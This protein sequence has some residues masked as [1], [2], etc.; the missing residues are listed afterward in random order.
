M[1]KIRKHKVK[2][3]CLCSPDKSISITNSG[4]N[5]NIMP[6]KIARLDTNQ[7]WAIS[8]KVAHP[9]GLPFADGESKSD[10]SGHDGDTSGPFNGIEETYMFPTS[11]DKFVDLYIDRI[12]VI[13]AYK[14]HWKQILNTIN[15]GSDYISDNDVRLIKSRLEML[16]G[17]YESYIFIPIYDEYPSIN[18]NHLKTPEYVETGKLFPE[19][20]SLERALPDLYQQ[21]L[22]ERPNTTDKTVIENW[23]TSI[24]GPATCPVYSISPD[25]GSSV[26]TG[27]SHYGDDVGSFPW[28]INWKLGRAAYPPRP[29][30]VWYSFGSESATVIPTPNPLP[31]P[32]APYGLP[33]DGITACGWSEPFPDFLSYVY[34][35][36]LNNTRDLYTRVYTQIEENPDIVKYGYLIDLN[37][38]TLLN[39]ST[40]NLAK[41][42][43]ITRKTKQHIVTVDDE[44]DSSWVAGINFGQSNVETTGI[45]PFPG[46]FNFTPPDNYRICDIDRSDYNISNVD[47]LNDLYRIKFEG[48]KDFSKVTLKVD[49]NSFPV[50]TTPNTPC[51]YDRET[52]GVTGGSYDTFSF[53]IEEINFF[54]DIV[55]LSDDGQSIY[56]KDVLPITKIGEN[57]SYDIMRSSPIFDSVSLLHKT[58]SNFTGQDTYNSSLGT[59]SIGFDTHEYKIKSGEFST[60]DYTD[61]YNIKY[62]T[63]FSSEKSEPYPVPMVGPFYRNSYPYISDETAQVRCNFKQPDVKYLSLHL[64]SPNLDIYHGWV[65]ANGTYIYC[66][67]NSQSCSSSVDIGNLNEGRGPDNLIFSDTNIEDIVVYDIPQFKII[68]DGYKEIDL[69]VYRSGNIDLYDFNN[70]SGTLLNGNIT[71]TFFINSS[72]KDS[73]GIE[74]SVF[75]TAADFYD[76]MNAV[77]LDYNPVYFSDYVGLENST[78]K[79][80]DFDYMKKSPLIYD[81][82]GFSNNEIVLN[83][84]TQFIGINQRTFYGVEHTK[85]NDSNFWIENVR[86]F[87]IDDVWFDDVYESVLIYEDVLMGPNP[88]VGKIFKRFLSVDGDDS[89]KKYWESFSNV[90]AIFSIYNTLPTI[91]NNMFNVNLSFSIQISQTDTENV[92]D[93]KIRVQSVYGDDTYSC[94]EDTLCNKSTQ[95]FKFNI[96]FPVRLFNQF[97][98]ISTQ[99]RPMKLIVKPLE[100][101]YEFSSLLVKP[102]IPIQD[103]ENV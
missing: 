4:D 61:S 62:T 32:N 85:C 73:S 95:G 15:G 89:N 3:N 64:D 72:T 69:S 63:S 59:N 91:Q 82:L 77:V 8:S 99:I 53:E 60:Y 76:Q 51:G 78:K 2:G 5:Y 101:D 26:L 102:N 50:L 55:Q 33:L 31:V 39:N 14:L 29:M 58:T 103:I 10:Y 34:E 23:I 66:P 94:E 1:S 54:D 68:K 44:R 87:K 81:Y 70:I 79:F 38:P 90:V 84:A 45:S 13:G 22:N 19:P 24:A 49:G 74:P 86:G 97:G 6:T 47:R 18:K 43:K 9:V 56:I 12:N 37:D 27:F 11:I 36:L 65:G 42:V 96:Q 16:N 40:W 75:I 80:L 93:A 57:G 25:G 20:F 67:Y 46:F 88:I 17:T 98:E 71:D 28:W 35:L 30:D 100:F 48:I 7:F 41:K 52:G 92:G 83:G 21:Y